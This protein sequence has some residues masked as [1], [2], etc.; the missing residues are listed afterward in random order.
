LALT[1]LCSCHRIAG[2]PHGSRVQVEHAVLWP[3]FTSATGLAKGCSDDGGAPREV[4]GGKPAEL[5]LSSYGRWIISMDPPALKLGGLVFLFQAP[6]EYGDFL[7]VR[8][9]STRDEIFPRV[10]VAPRHRVDL[11]DGWSE[12]FIPFGELDPRSAAF[13]RLIF[14]AALPIGTTRV[15]LDSIGFTHSTRRRGRAGRGCA[16]RAAKRTRRANG[17]RLPRSLPAHQPDDLRN[18]L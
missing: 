6:E 18:C 8:L 1:L 4:V 14:R 15:K 2:R 5:D 11:A 16:N 13:D 3:V 17:D 9:D 7:E 10:R 12:V